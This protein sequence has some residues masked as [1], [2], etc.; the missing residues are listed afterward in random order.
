MRITPWKLLVTPFLSFLL[1]SN[2][3]L[4]AQPNQAPPLAA[5]VVPPVACQGFQPVCSTEKVNGNCFVNIDRKYAITTP[6]FKLH[7]GSHITVCVF[8]PFPFET[9]TLDPGPASAYQGTDQAA[10]LVTSLLTYGK[11]AVF[12]TTSYTTVNATSQKDYEFN[13][14]FDSKLGKLFSESTS[15]LNAESN[16]SRVTEL[17]KQVSQELKDLNST[18]TDAI[19][20]VVTY[21][22]DTNSIYAQIR[23]VESALPRPVADVH[24]TEL[25]A[26][27]V[28]AHRANPWSDYHAWKTQ[29]TSDLRGQGSESTT[30]LDGL[31]GP[32]YD[33]ATDPAPPKGPWLPSP[34]ICPKGTTNKTAQPPQTPLGIPASYDVLDR[35]M[36]TDFAQLSA[37]LPDCT[38]GQPNPSEDCQQYLKIKDSIAVLSDRHNRVA[39]ALSDATD[40]LPG[41]LTKI[42]SD[43]QTLYENIY[44]TPDTAP[45]SVEVGVIPGPDSVAPADAE[46]K[47]ILTVYKAL[48]PTITYTLNEQNQIA[49]SLLGLPAATQKQSV[50]AIT[51]LYAAPRFEASAGAF[52]SWLPNRTFSN[53][54]NVAVTGGVPAPTSIQIQM[55]KT[56]PPLVVPF[57]AANYR[58]SPEYAWLGGRRSAFYLTAGV[59]LNAYDTQVEYPAGFS[60]SWRYLMISPLYHLGH[61]THLING[62]M[63]GQTWC[64]YGNGATATSTPPVCAGAPPVPATKSYWTGQFAIG[65]S[66][67]VPTTYA[68]TNQ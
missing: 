28:P 40:L 21:F 46:E 13:L 53:V 30:L 31:P 68:S 24:N 18:L 8:H 16:P 2:S 5:P 17:E 57:A 34:R 64:Q 60:F 56:T 1:L 63:V 66:V 67:R 44:L 12:G 7:R 45:E 65:I 27:G 51:A 22:H 33:K 14:Q 39:Q 9:L 41:I 52:F 50:A 47:K 37:L 29:I 59:G 10:A 58:I 43:M 49:N 3:M 11:G 23:E 54:T 6:T 42:T 61:S 25:L 38:P 35:T 62:E 4:V 26:Q 48:A 19:R 36:L 55:T 20:P 32:C 15:R